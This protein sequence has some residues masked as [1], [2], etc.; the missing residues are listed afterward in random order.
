MIAPQLL[1]WHGMA[2]LSVTNF[3]RLP[4][5]SLVP[6][7]HQ[8]RCLPF[9]MGSSWMKRDPEAIFTLFF[10]IECF[11]ARQISRFCFAV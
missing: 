5:L 11:G 1:C 6:F 9:S 10:F 2:L 3:L 7:I 4:F 8:C